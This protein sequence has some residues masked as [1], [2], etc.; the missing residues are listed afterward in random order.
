MCSIPDRRDFNI[1]GSRIRVPSGLRMKRWRHCLADYHDPNLVGYLE[2]GWPVN[3]RE[4]TVQQSNLDNY[5]AANHYAE[6]VDHY[7]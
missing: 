6:H 2:Y 4:G 3:F 5:P 1:R 7:V